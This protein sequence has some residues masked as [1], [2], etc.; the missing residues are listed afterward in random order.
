[1]P[2]NSDLAT[3][4]SSQEIS[5]IR[6]EGRTFSNR[7][8]VLVMRPNTLEMSR[9]AVIASRSVGGAVERNRCKRR[10]RSRVAKLAIRIIP[11]NDFL[12]IARVACLSVEPVLLDQAFEQV[13]A[14]AG[15]LSVNV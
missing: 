1:M 8:F 5:A 15:L 13:F 2:G 14:Q 9:Y 10:I 12:I 7:Y 11:G 6:K 3:L 4:R